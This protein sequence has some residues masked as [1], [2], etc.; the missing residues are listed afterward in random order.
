MGKG[1]QNLPVAQARREDFHFRKEEEPHQIRKEAII[2][3]HPEVTKLM[4]HEWRTK[5]IVLATVALQV[6][7]AFLVRDWSWPYFLAAAYVVGATANHSLF[8]AIHE[9]SH[10][11]G[12]KG[13]MGNRLC[14]M[15]GNWPIGIAYSVTFKPYH[16]EH[17]RHQGT[18]G[19]DTD[20]PTALEAYLITGTSG[21]YVTHTAK[22]AVFMFCQIFA[23]AFRPM[24]VKPEVVPM[25]RWLLINWV[26]QLSF[27]GAMCY[28]AAFWFPSPVGGHW[29]NVMWYLLFSTLLAGSIHPTAGHFIAEHYVME[30]VTET[31]SY[32]GPLNCLAYN[33]G[34]HNEHHDFPN[35][36]WSRL[37]EVRKVAPEFYDH[38]PQCKSWPGVILR[39]IFDDSIGPYS[40]VKKDG[41]CKAE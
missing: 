8:L 24:M 34:Y 27:D 3:A 23:Y 32:Y 15:F 9:L 36:P 14:A 41:A 20:I 2:K 13:I 28:A 12:F 1:S 5:Y 18:H 21:S 39:Y 17:H 19:V 7:M 25:D 30:G 6:G 10:N 31:Y 35:I 37:P 16:M 29:F 33:V 40:R 4:G 22:K 11:L 26:S 38:L